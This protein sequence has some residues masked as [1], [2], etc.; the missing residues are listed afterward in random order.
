MLHIVKMLRFQNAL[1][2]TTLMKLVPKLV[3]NLL[4][5]MVSVSLPRG[6][7]FGWSLVPKLLIMP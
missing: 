3:K 2:I 6:L 5:V 7:E 4:K 1:H